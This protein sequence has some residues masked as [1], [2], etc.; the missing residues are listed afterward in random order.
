MAPPP[1]R[2][3]FLIGFGLSCAAVVCNIIGFS[4]PFWFQSYPSAHSTF[5]SIGLW[6]ACF[7]NFQHPAD[8]IG[9]LYTGCWWIFHTEYWNMRDWLLPPFCSPYWFQSWPRVHSEFKRIGLWEACFAGFIHPRDELGKAYHGCWWTFSKEYWN[10]RDWLLPPWFISVQVMVTGTLIC[11][12]VGAILL[13]AYFLRCC[14]PQTEAFALFVS[15]GL[16]F[17]CA[18]LMGVS[19]LVFGVM[20]KEDRTWMPRPELNYMSW[21]YGL[22]VLS[23]FFAFFSGLA[24]AVQGMIVKERALEKE[25]HEMAPLPPKI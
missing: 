15:A 19:V 4:S 17:V 8:Y 10:I 21:S 2:V 22:A 9:K 20:A 24:L 11:Q 14:R 7:Q 12:L 13:V 18:F 6:Q 23:A 16:Q 25:G 3:M 1:E 5:R